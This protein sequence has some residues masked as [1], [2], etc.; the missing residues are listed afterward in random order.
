M[1]TTHGKQKPIDFLK[2]LPRRRID[3]DARL[4][5]V[6]HVVKDN[7]RKGNYELRQGQPEFKL[8]RDAVRY[9]VQL[10]HALNRIPFWDDLEGTFVFPA[11]AESERTWRWKLIATSLDLL[12]SDSITQEDLLNAM[13]QVDAMITIMR[14]QFKVGRLSENSSPV[15]G[16]DR[17]FCAVTLRSIADLLEQVWRPTRA[18]ILQESKR[19]RSK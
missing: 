7:F 17:Y 6:F 19:R 9:L 18:R 12:K 3:P 2:H 15:P 10:M 4:E 13:D 14:R 8:V 16:E 1:K 5:A 11:V